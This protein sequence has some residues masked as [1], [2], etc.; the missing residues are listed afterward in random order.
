M[1]LDVCRCKQWIALNLGQRPSLPVLQVSA[2]GSSALTAAVSV[3]PA[4][5]RSSVGCI[6]PLVVRC[7]TPA[8]RHTEDKQRTKRVHYHIFN[9]SEK[10]LGNVLKIS[11]LLE[12][13]Q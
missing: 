3:S 5:P 9:R 10:Q 7:V 1:R 12:G 4:E 2:L 6:E 8:L 11:R 13:I